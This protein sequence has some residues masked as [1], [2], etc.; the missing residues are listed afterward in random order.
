MNLTKLNRAET[1]LVGN[2]QIPGTESIR[3][4]AA[5]IVDFLTEGSHREFRPIMRLPVKVQHPDG[6][7]SDAE[8]TGYY[9][10]DLPSIGYPLPQGGKTHGGLREGDRLLTQVPSYEEW[11]HW[12][13]K[14]QRLPQKDN[15]WQYIRHLTRQ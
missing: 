10:P 14:Q 15:P 9:E 12:V 8:F 2:L 1:I 11:E 7:V 6:S 3:K 13:E 5:I 4:D